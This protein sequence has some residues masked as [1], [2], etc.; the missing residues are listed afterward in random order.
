MLYRISIPIPDY[1]GKAVFQQQFYL[2][3]ETSPTFG[4]TLAIVA[5]LHLRDKVYPTYLGCWQKCAQ[6]IIKASKDWPT[7]RGALIETNTFVKVKIGKKFVRSSLSV[8][9]I[10][11]IKIGFAQLETDLKYWIDQYI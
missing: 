1:E 10:R 9:L 5:K 6:A 2:D 7:L 8:R 11:P 3:A 4:Q